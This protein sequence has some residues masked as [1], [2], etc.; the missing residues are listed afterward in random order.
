MKT[1][2]IILSVLAVSLLTACDPSLLDIPQQ[3][4][5]SEDTFYK[6]DGDAEQAIAT[7]YQWWRNMESGA[8]L[9]GVHYANGFM[10]RNLLSDELNTGGSRSDQPMLQEFN[11]SA[12]SVTNAV[13]Q[14]YY[15]D[16]FKLIYKAHL[17]MEHFDASESAVKKRAVAEAH[18]FRAWAYLYLVTLWGTPPYIDHSVEPDK[19]D[20]ENG[21]PAL[22]WKLIED[23]MEACINSGALGTKRNADDQEGGIRLTTEAAQAFYGR[24]LLYEGKYA[25]A[26]VQLKKVIDSGK[27]GLVPA[28][29]FVYFYHT[30]NNHCKEYVLEIN[31]HY[32]MANNGWGSLNGTMTT[33]QSGW[34]A[35]L[36]NWGFNYGV[37]AGPESA[38]YFDLNATT[39]YSNGLVPKSLYDDYKAAGEEDGIRRKATILSLQDLIDMNIFFDRTMA[40]YMN[41]G[42]WR[43]KWLPLLQDEN[44][45]YWVGSMACTPMIRYADVLLMMAECC[46]KT[47]ESGDAYF[48]QVRTRAGVPTKTGVTLEDI[49]TERH[50]ELALEGVRYHDLLRWGDAPKALANKGK[51][52]PTLRLVPPANLDITSAAAIY[53]AKYETS[54]EYVDND[55]S[56][57]GWTAGRDE[58]LPFPQAEIDVNKNLVQNPGYKD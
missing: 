6:T 9:G 41:E 27:Y 5:I 7:C 55:K 1:R 22:I 30:T 32:D 33:G 2:Y 31:R 29:K 3:G 4:V 24:A 47:G 54:V 19:G 51:R 13:V 20:L 21:D 12:V 48:N 25:E 23:D 39:G 44:V 16:L 57:S 15:Q 56:L 37:C 58:L 46:V 35:I 14:G 40:M 42:Y 43:F 18:F 53:A 36:W 50:L 17:V 49:K 34:F 45:N 8:F 52:L 11:E 38:N 26:K 28:D 10:M